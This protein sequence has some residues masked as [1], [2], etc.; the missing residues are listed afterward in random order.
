[1]ELFEKPLRDLQKN[2]E[3]E[4]SKLALIEKE[5]ADAELHSRSFVEYLNTRHLFDD[6]YDGDVEGEYFWMF[7][8]KKIKI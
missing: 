7:Y 1:M 8:S 4:Y 3:E 6:L 5:K 2:E